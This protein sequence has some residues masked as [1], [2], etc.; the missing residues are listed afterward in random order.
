MGF[1]KKKSAV[2][3]DVVLHVFHGTCIL[4]HSLWPCFIVGWLFPPSPNP[5]PLIKQNTCMFWEVLA[6]HPFHC[7]PG[8]AVMW[9]KKKIKKSQGWNFRATL[10]TV[11]CV[12]WALYKSQARCWCGPRAA[13]DSGWKRSMLQLPHTSVCLSSSLFAEIALDKG[14]CLLSDPWSHFQCS[15]L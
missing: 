4:V 2:R 14:T 3:I 12:Q 10:A 8:S 7:H 13:R 6:T 9:L 11:G 1:W 5:C 15:L